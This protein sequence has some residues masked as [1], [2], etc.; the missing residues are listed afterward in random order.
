MRI[1][2]LLSSPNGQSTIPI[3]Y[4]YHMAAAI[5]QILSTA[6]PEYA[7]FLHRQGHLGPDGKPRKL[8][9]FSKLYFIPKAT[10]QGNRLLVKARSRVELV[11]SSPMLQ[12]FLQHFVIGLFERQRIDIGDLEGRMTLLVQQV[13]ALPEP[14]FGESTRF[15]CLSPIVLTTQIDT[16]H[17]M[18]TYF[19]RPL[20]FGLAEAVRK[21]LLGKHKTAYGKAPDSDRLHFAV[22]EAYIQRQG[23]QEGVSKKI[24]IREGH[25]DKTEV[26][27]FVAPF[28][29]TGS[30]ELMRTAWECGLGD[31][32]SMGF[33]CVEVKSTLN[34]RSKPQRSG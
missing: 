32:C 4:Q 15:I 2:L 5:Y 9:T 14:V 22:D 34:L 3:N 6:S 27:A 13:E 17:G 7:E 33:G 26:K 25:E 29:L 20:D 11:V 23:G 8:F 28:T 21:N 19:Y 24:T 12:D 16:S 10:Q 31:K 18:G 30:T 1:K